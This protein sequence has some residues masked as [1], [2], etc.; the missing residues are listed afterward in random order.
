MM[1]VLGVRHCGALMRI[2]R[3]ILVQR[4]IVLNVLEGYNFRNDGRKA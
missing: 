2:E 1:I 3:V 4:F